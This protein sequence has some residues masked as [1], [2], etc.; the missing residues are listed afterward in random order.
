MSTT[1]PWHYLMGF[2]QHNFHIFLSHF[3]GLYSSKYIPHLRVCWSSVHN[4]LLST[5]WLFCSLSGLR[6]KVICSLVTTNSLTSLQPDC[7]R[8][9]GSEL[10][11][12]FYFHT[13]SIL[14]IPGKMFEKV[15]NKPVHA[16]LLL[17]H[18]RAFPSCR[19]TRWARLCCCWSRVC[20]VCCQYCGPRCCSL[21]WAGASASPGC[22]LSHLLSTQSRRKRKRRTGNSDINDGQKGGDKWSKESY[23][24]VS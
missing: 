9:G 21:R 14:W 2:V 15:M 5:Q 4:A 24:M 17:W 1:P 16:E 11:F 6:C 22:R 20:F 23:E 8:S 19:V 18:G 3:F 12:L 10:F 13:F 7:C